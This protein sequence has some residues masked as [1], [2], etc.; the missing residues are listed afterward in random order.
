MAPQMTSFP[1]QPR[2]YDPCPRSTETIVV[3]LCIYGGNAGGVAA[4][5]Q[6]ARGGRRVVLVENSNH[7][8]GLTASGLGLTDFGNKAVLGGLAREFYTRIGRHYGV[9]E[10]LRFEPRV[11][12]HVFETW[13]REANFRVLR[14]EFLQ[15]VNLTDRRISEIRLESGRIIRAGIFIDASYEG[16]LLA[17]AGVTFVVGREDNA[18]H[19]ETIN[20]MVIRGKHQFE[21]PV[22]PYRIRNTPASGLL[23]GIESGEDFSAGK[24]DRRIQAYNFRMCLTRDPKNRRP[25]LRPA[26][27]DRLEY[28]LLARYFE[29]G[30]R[31]LFAKFDPIRGDK[32]DTNNHGAVSTDFIG[33]N[34]RWPEA[35]FAERENI[36]QAHVNYQQGLQWFLSHDSSV[37]ADLREE[38]SQWGLAADEFVDTGGWPHALYIREARRM[39]GDYVM[40]ENDCRGLRRAPDPVCLGAYGMDSHNCRRVIL[41]GRLWNEGDVQEAGFKPYPISLRSLLPPRGECSN[42]IVATCLSASHIAYGS[43]RMEPVFLTLGQAAAICADLTLQEKCRTHDLPYAAV[44]ERLLAAGQVLELS[45][46][47]AVPNQ[48]V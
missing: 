14:R 27:Y 29:A 33:R 10:E 31:D 5:V 42:L 32:T 2:Y 15:S 13:A 4:A 8:G 34:H 44:R 20:G 41:N 36:F 23:P 43:I 40:T 26:N 3:D 17:A 22:D 39:V 35:G 12:E 47:D 1:R 7:L 11:A 24:G 38:Y 18:V 19:G 30:W 48:V 21:F 25:F 16:D 28:E 45:D 9:E 46:A 37:P 6:A